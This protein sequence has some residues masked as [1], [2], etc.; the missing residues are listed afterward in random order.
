V[1]FGNNKPHPTLSTWRGF[2]VP[3]LREKGR[4]EVAFGNNKPHPK[5]LST[6]RG[7]FTLLH[8]EKGRDEV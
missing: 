6:W 8:V 4:D 2:F 5:S 3:S 1:A 7:T